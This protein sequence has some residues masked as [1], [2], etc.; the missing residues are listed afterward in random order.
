MQYRSFRFVLAALAALAF[1]PAH[2]TYPSNCRLGG[3]SDHCTA[4][5]YVGPTYNFCYTL[6]TSDQISVYW[7]NAR[8]GQWVNG[9]CSGAPALTADAI[10]PVSLAFAKAAWERPDQC[11]VSGVDDNWGQ[12]VPPDCDPGQSPRMQYGYL[13]ND[14]QK[15][16]FTGSSVGAGSCPVPNT[17]NVYAYSHTDLACNGHSPA[18][19][20]ITNMPYCA[21]TQDGTCNTSV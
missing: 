11:A 6:G 16:E 2:A 17:F 10:Y 7:C 12:P 9:G 18:V 14:I 5:D 13:I 1:S 8:G 21:P 15:M 20:P 19:D 3:G 4:I